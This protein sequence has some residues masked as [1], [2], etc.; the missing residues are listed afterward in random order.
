MGG[1]PRGAQRQRI[2]LSRYAMNII[3]ADSIAF[4]DSPNVSGFVNLILRNIWQT[5]DASISLA[6]KR[7]HE[8]L[9][10][11]LKKEQYTKQAYN[12]QQL[13]FFKPCAIILPDEEKIVDLLLSG[14]C[15]QLIETMTAFPKEAS[16][17]IRLQNDV[18]DNLGLRE[19][20]TWTESE[21]YKQHSD[22]VKALL[23]DYAHKSYFDREAIFFATDID[24]V[25]RE[26]LLPDNEK[27]ILSIEYKT[28]NG[29]MRH[30]NCKPHRIVADDGRNFHYLVGMSA[31]ADSKESK[32]VEAV[33]RISRIKK[34]SLRAKSFGSGKLKKYEQEALQQS[35]DRKGVQYLIAKEEEFQIRLTPT[36]IKW[37]GSFVYQRP[38]YRDKRPCPDGNTVLVFDCT[39]AQIENY[40]FKFG[41][42]AIIV[43]PKALATDFLRRYKLAF[44]EYEEA[45]K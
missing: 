16:L 28:A 24:F 14:Y 31:D 9:I 22:Y 18:Y 15:R 19:D 43:A 11:T 42:E 26:L 8:R 20:W 5:S 23:E 13:A 41:K 4:M 45:Q 27:R 10:D 30:Y 29:D 1:Y 34:V 21:Y 35:I 6:R 44:E 39:K 25:R 37:Y 2:S 38:V 12:D 7:E 40:F 32:Y 36:G 3:E 17:N 33:F